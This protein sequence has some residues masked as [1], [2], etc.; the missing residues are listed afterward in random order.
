VPELTEGKVEGKV[1]SMRE[2]LAEHRSNPACASCHRL[3]DPLGFALENYD[4]VGRWRGGE[5][6][7]PIDASGSL[8]NGTTFEGAAGLREAL[9]SRPELFVTATTEKLLTYAL[10]RGLEHY[11]SPAVREIVRDAARNNFRFSSLISGIVNST[12][13]QMRRSQ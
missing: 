9:M 7:M 2:R 12:P 8:P 6:G 13:F 11:D 4:A 1:L 3:M 5:E 10:G